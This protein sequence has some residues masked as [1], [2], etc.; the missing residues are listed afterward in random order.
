MRLAVTALPVLLLGI[1]PSSARAQAGSEE[2][3]VR[4]ALDHYLQGH[5]TGDGAHHRMAF[6]PQANLYFVQNGALT[7]LSSEEYASRSSGKPAADEAQRKRRIVSVDISG[8]AAIAKIELD[9]PNVRLV[10]YMS[11]LKVNG[12][13]KIIAKIF[14]RQNKAAP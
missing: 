10:D 6:Y 4:K 7:T 2:A 13:W 9:Y 11:L 5:A 14:D 1:V 12:E 3:A 8:T